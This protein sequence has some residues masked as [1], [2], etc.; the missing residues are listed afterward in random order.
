MDTRQIIGGVGLDSRIGA[1]YKNASFGYGGYCL[2]K[3]TKQLLANYSG[4][5]QNLIRAIVDA[6]LERLAF[7]GSS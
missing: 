1:H 4:V 3:G 6:N 5:P 7:S 2:P